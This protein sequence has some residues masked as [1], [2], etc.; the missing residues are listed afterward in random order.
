MQGWLVSLDAVC[1]IIDKVVGGL[2]SKKAD[3]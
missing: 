1:Q 3:Q 2:D